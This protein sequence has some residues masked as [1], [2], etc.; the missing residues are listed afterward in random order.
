V[1]GSILS[2]FGGGVATTEQPFASSL[3]LA[4]GLPWTLFLD[5]LGSTD[6]L[7][8][9]SPPVLAILAPALN[10]AILFSFCTTLRR[11]RTLPRP[12]N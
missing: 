7:T 8:E 6:Y 12:E 2:P 9:V 4:L 11:R 10:L 5:S 1:L 3:L